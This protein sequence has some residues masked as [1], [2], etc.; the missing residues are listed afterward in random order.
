MKRPDIN[1]A[2]NP[3]DA[4]G[5]FGVGR[6]HIDVPVFIDIEGERLLKRTKPLTATLKIR[7]ASQNRRTDLLVTLLKSGMRKG[8]KQRN[9]P[10]ER[11]LTNFR[12][13]KPCP[14]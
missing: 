1:L 11:R 5:G 7:G 14:S 9:R 10:V 13:L 12:R 8:F 2:Q 6:G 3:R 4:G